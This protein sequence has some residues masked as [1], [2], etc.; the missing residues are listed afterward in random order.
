MTLNKL[1]KTYGVSATD[2]E[3][4][5]WGNPINT[6]KFP[7]S[8][9]K[10]WT[11][12]SGTFDSDGAFNEI[13][14]NSINVIRS[15][16]PFLMS[17]DTYWDQ[18][19]ESL[20]SFVKGAIYQVAVHLILNRNLWERINTSGTQVPNFTQ[21]VD[22]TGW[23]VPVDMLSQFSNNLLRGSEIDQYELIDTGDRYA[24]QETFDNNYQLVGTIDNT[25]NLTL[26]YIKKVCTDNGVSDA[27][28]ALIAEE[29]KGGL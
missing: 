4:N 13:L 5:G 11:N 26:Q 7:A 22:T 8:Y 1:L 27:T 20:T 24:V 17:I 23:L 29:I 6:L 10:R 25:N 15:V 21:T 18:M 16:K 14:I 2:F 19:P 3:T 9:V 28:A 12:S